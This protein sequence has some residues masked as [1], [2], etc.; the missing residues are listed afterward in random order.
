MRKH[1]YMVHS[2][3]IAHVEV[4]CEQCGGT[5]EECHYREERTNFCSTDCHDEWRSENKT[6]PNSP[7]WEGGP[8]I[9]TCEQC[10]DEYEIG[11]SVK[12]QSRFCSRR[13]HA[14]WQSE[15]RVGENSP[16]WKGGYDR[17]RRSVWWPARKR[18]LERDGYQCQVCGM[19]REEHQ[20]EYGRD[21][22]VHHIRPARSFDDSED[23]HDLHNLVVLCMSC[24]RTWEGIPLA[25]DRRS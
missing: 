24:H 18:A 23:A 10:G 15:N 6:G 4:E 14:D 22:E 1:H 17:Y 19:S 20:E 8:A 21:L 12:D 2:E 25:P 13:C 9:N 11:K 7:S 5:Y 3:S 16:S